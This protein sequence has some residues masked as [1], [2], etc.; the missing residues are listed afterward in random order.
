MPCADSADAAGATPVGLAKAMQA[1]DARPYCD[2]K[3]RDA[4]ATAAASF[5]HPRLSTIDAKLAPAAVEPSPEKSSILVEFIVPNGA[6]TR[7]D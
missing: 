2:H 1:G 4:M 7:E 3:R 5:L 6:R